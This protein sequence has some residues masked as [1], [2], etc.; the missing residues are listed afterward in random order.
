MKKNQQQKTWLEA[1][2]LTSTDAIKKNFTNVTIKILLKQT[3]T[4]RL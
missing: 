1:D 3:L 2:L 4:R